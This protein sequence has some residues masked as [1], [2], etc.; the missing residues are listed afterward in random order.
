[1]DETS[2]TADF[3]K[4]AYN[5]FFYAWIPILL[6][7][8]FIV[9]VRMARSNIAGLI[10]LAIAGI[11][12]GIAISTTSYQAVYE[13]GV[14]L[15]IPLFGALLLSGH[16]HEMY[17]IQTRDVDPVYEAMKAQIQKDIEAKKI[18]LV[19]ARKREE[20]E[21]AKVDIDDF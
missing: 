10:A 18:E 2:W 13:V 4:G 1:V 8:L 5:F 9:V 14:F 15:L 19:E 6:F 11:G 12:L 3:L 7:W 17:K 20:K 21:R 16:Y